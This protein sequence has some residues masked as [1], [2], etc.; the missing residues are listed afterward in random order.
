MVT[1]RM[2]HSSVLLRRAG[3]V[4]SPISR[5]LDNRI[6][7]GRPT[8]LRTQTP[9]DQLVSFMAT[10]QAPDGLFTEDVFCDFTMPTWRLQASG[11]ADTIALRRYG[12]PVPGQVMT[13]RV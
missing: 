8:M 9:T 5:L 2:R 13:R 4:S 6:N 12:H 1:D 11:A 10:G 7:D 3:T